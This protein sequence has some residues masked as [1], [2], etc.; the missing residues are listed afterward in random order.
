MKAK[1]LLFE[2]LLL[3]EHYYVLFAIKKSKFPKPGAYFLCCR[4][5]HL[6]V[7]EYPM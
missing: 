5:N 1:Q 3:L 7:A 4:M 6:Q 2:H